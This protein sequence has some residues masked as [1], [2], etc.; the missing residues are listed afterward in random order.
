MSYLKI[1]VCKMYEIKTTTRFEKDLKLI[2]KRGYDTKLL[3]EVI[4]ILS[5]GENQ[6]KNIKIIIYK[7]IIQ[8][9]KSA[10]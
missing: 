10:I 6:K 9:L 5:K 8:D 7:E 2:K 4:D 3:K 1:Q